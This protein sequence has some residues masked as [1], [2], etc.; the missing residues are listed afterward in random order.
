M[1]VLVAG[2]H[3]LAE[4]VLQRAVG[5]FDLVYALPRRERD[6]R[7]AAA[8]IAAERLGVPVVADAGEPALAAVIAECL[9]SVVLSCGYDRIIRPEVFTA[10]EHCA[11]VH[12]GDLPRYRGSLSIPRA[13]LNGECRIGV[14]LHEV[15]AGIDD[16]PIIEQQHIADDGLRS[17]RAL[18]D[19]AVTLGADMAIRWLGRID[20]GEVVEVSPQDESEATYYAPEHP[21]G[22]RIVWRQTR[23]QVMRQIRAAHFPP[24][25]SA[26]SSVDGVEISFNWPVVGTEDPA[27][28]TEGSVVKAGDGR[29]GVAVLNG[30]VVPGTVVANGEHLDFQ[31][32]VAASD[33]AGKRFA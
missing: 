9:P 17:C 5:K 10:V 25:P 24:F 8:R 29:Y 19:E 12:F 21:Y 7:D 1:R 33:L 16:G 4:T 28:A 20:A 15:A 22:F 14:T 2:Q 11:N 26:A 32:L 13:I 30:I 6:N 31:D 27:R 18:Y 3:E 23:L